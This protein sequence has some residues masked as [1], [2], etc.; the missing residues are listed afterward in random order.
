MQIS[1]SGR[2]LQIPRECVCCGGPA[3]VSFGA[4]AT[5]TRG[6][7]VRARVNNTRTNEWTFHLCEFC[8]AHDRRES[9]YAKSATWPA[10]GAVIALI[11]AAA[12]SQGAVAPG[13]ALLVIGG[14]IAAAGISRR[15]T[16]REKAL[17]PLRPE[18]TDRRAQ[19]LVRYAGWS[20]SVH[21]FFI[22]APRYAKAFIVA[23]QGKTINA[24]REIVA[25]LESHR[26]PVPTYTP[27]ASTRSTQSDTAS[28][29]RK[30]DELRGEGLITEDE[31]QTRR[32]RILEDV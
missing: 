17:T 22:T 14:V 27:I 11:G 8:A 9:A 10:L 2:T 29:L 3:E 30:L 26:P 25:I 15:R 6:K 19:S 18:C 20:G 23:N 16:L 21:T 1:V 28:R 13:I 4:S 12:L 32:A 7:T 5:Q 24:S 31:Y